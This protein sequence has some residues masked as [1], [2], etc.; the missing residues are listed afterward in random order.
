MKNLVCFCLMACFAVLSS[1]GEAQDSPVAVVKTAQG[2]PV[3]VRG[4]QTLPAIEGGRVMAGDVLRTGPGGSL[5]LI[6]KDDTI[7]ALGP[8][9][10]VVMTEFLFVP[11]D[12]KLSFVARVVRGTASFVTGAI[13]KLSPQSVRI[14]TPKAVIGIRGTHI[15][16]K[17]DAPSP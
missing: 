5:G 13:G 12:K 6:F 8:S 15:L 17:V 4:A 9:S 2:S 16:V 1:P 3:L 14:Q 10:E 7:L 11:A